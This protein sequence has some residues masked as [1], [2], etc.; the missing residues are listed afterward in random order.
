MKAITKER[1]VTETYT[2]YEA[3]DG[4]LFKTEEACK[5]Y[6]ESAKCAVRMRLDFKKLT[7]DEENH[8]MWYALNALD[9]LLE[10]GC[11]DSEY[12]LW[13]PK[14]EDAIKNYLQWCNLIGCCGFDNGKCYGDY[15]YRCKLE[16]IKPN[17]T[18]IVEVYEDG[19]YV[20]V[21]NTNVFKN[22]VSKMFNVLTA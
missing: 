13:T 3:N 22:A 14:T 21:I 19:E 10:N 11:E 18:Y 15:T 9:G 8:A 4:T 20:S 1:T 12:F 6:D 7:G 5:K 16:D 17:E 2:M